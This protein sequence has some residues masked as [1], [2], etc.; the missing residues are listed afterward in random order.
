V[1]REHVGQA[2]IADL[3]F[4]ADR[5]AVHAVERERNAALDLAIDVEAEAPAAR[6][7]VVDDDRAARHVAAVARVGK[8]QDAV[9]DHLRRRRPRVPHQ[10]VEV[11]DVDEQDVR[12]GDPVAGVGRMLLRR[13]VLDVRLRGRRRCASLRISCW[14]SPTPPARLEDD[15]VELAVAHPLDRQVVDVRTP[16]QRAAAAAVVLGTAG[17]VDEIEV[18]LAPASGSRGSCRGRAT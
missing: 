8:Q 10:V 16:R 7:Q 5:L 2:R 4:A 15:D 3:A 6:R 9:L 1:R 12:V 18:V 14:T 11:G 13:I 17:V